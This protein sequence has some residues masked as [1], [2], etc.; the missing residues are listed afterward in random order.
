[1]TKNNPPGYPL[2]DGDLGE[3]EIVCQLVYLPD[4][5]EYWQALL[6]AVHYFSTWTAWERDDD[7][8]GKDAAA[9]WRDAFE[10][11]IGCW[12]MT[13]LEDLTQTVTDI[14]ELLQT[15]KD[16]CDDNITYL[17]V[18]EI[19]TD[20]IPFEGDPPE[21]YGETEIVDWDD[22]AEHVCYNAHLYV[23]YLAHAGDSLWDATKN[24]SIIIG[25]VAAIL[26]LLAF[27]GIGLPIAYGLAAGIVSGIVLGGQIATFAGTF[28]AI[29]EAR[30]DIVCAIINGTG[31]AEAV[32][33]AL[34]SG[35]D[36]DLFYQVI[37]YESALA[38][39][40]EGGHEEEYLPAET[41]D[42]CDCAPPEEHIA[43]FTMTGELEDAWLGGDPTAPWDSLGGGSIIIN[44]A[45]ATNEMTV[46]SIRAHMSLGT[47]AGD[48]IF[49]SKIE[50][51]WRCSI[52]TGLARITVWGDD[53]YTQNIDFGPDTAHIWHDGLETWLEEPFECSHPLTVF[54]VSRLASF[55]AVWFD[56]IKIYFTTEVV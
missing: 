31:L 8:R 14:L 18:D 43:I 17:P 46:E 53:S 12:R 41:R 6:A 32:E 47:E 37:P 29:E 16:C 52:D 55:N 13:C 36:W 21:V 33:D 38:I 23:D 30:D 5:P 19:E 39:I 27:S 4:R 49:I 28:E 54:R 22:W 50:L 45:Q 9:N 24:S 11:T 10:L 25:L 20:I 42:D 44:P 48:K 2:P 34:S 26:A 15:R 3:D 51:T 35:L 7:K 1:M 40:Y 56:N